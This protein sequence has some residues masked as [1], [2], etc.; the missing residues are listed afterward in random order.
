MTFLLALLAALVAVAVWD[1]LQRSHSIR[2][3][4]PIIGNLRY[5]LER[6]GPELRQ[7]LVTSNNDERPFSRDQRRWVYAS[8]KRENRY[9]GFGTDNE[10]ETSPNYLIIKH[11][12]LGFAGSDG[13]R[14]EPSAIQ[15]S[16]RHGCCRYI[17]FGAHRHRR[18]SH[19]EP[20]VVD[21]HSVEL[22]IHR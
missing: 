7:Y 14:I 2:R 10:L 3:N 20:V 9:F 18:I 6:V 22:G 19:L 11:E 12:T 13:D 16:M 1:V 21:A 15:G 17:A 8:A 5:L 4:F